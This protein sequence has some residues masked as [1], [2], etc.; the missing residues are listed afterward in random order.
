MYGELEDP[1]GFDERETQKLFLSGAGI[2]IL[3]N[4]VE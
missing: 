4:L 2:L 3:L 1:A